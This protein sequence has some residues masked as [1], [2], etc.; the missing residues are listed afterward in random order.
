MVHFWLNSGNR[1]VG[2]FG[3]LKGGTIMVVNGSLCWLGKRLEYTFLLNI[4]KGQ[5]LCCIRCI[6]HR[7]GTECRS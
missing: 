5:C 1:D 7:G 4:L 2:G 3:V 6:Y